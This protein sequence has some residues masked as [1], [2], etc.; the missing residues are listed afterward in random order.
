MASQSFHA[1]EQRQHAE[2][3][4]LSYDSTTQLT[5]SPIPRLL[6]DTPVES[7]HLKTCIVKDRRQC[8]LFNLLTPCCGY[9]LNLFVISEIWWAL[10]SSSPV[11]GPTSP[12]QYSTVLFRTI[13]TKTRPFV[14]RLTRFSALAV[15]LT[16]TGGAFG[17]LEKDQERRNRTDNLKRLFQGS[18]VTLKYV[19]EPSTGPV[20]TTCTQHTD[21]GHPFSP[22]F[23]GCLY[24]VSRS[25]H[26]KAGDV[27]A[28]IHNITWNENE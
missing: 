6:T 8:F 26:A 13:S 17:E 25:G 23:S 5:V 4:R 19:G 10:V 21:C 24:V 3:A 18:K 22:D 7:P 1:Y 20:I 9:I 2:H 14:V 11:K 27:T 16:S 15:L 28:F 12:L